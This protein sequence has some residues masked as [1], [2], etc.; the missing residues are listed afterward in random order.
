MIFK[1]RAARFAL[2]PFV[3]AYAVVWEWLTW[4]WLLL[5]TCMRGNHTWEGFTDGRRTLYVCT[6]CMKSI[7]LPKV[8]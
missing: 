4:I 1:S 7:R 8:E 2:R 5:T 3:I 6:R